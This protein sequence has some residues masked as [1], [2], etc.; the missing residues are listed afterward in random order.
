MRIQRKRIAAVIA[1]AL[2]VSTVFTGLPILKSSAASDGSSLVEIPLVNAGFE[3]PVETDGKI[4]GWNAEYTAASGLSHSVSGDSFKSGSKSLNLFDNI[5]NSDPAVSATAL[6]TSDMYEIAPGTEYTL[7]A[8]INPNIPAGYVNGSVGGSIYIRYYA[9]DGTEIDAAIKKA[10]HNTAQGQFTKVSVTQTAPANAKYVTASAAVTPVWV[11][12]TYFDD[13]SIAYSVPASGTVAMINPGFEDAVGPDNKIPGWNPEYTTVAGSVYHQIGTVARTGSKSLN[14]FDNVN[15]AGVTLLSDRY[16]VIP[17]KSYTLSAW[18]NRNEPVGRVD[19]SVGGTIHLRFYDASG[20]EITASR[21][22][23]NVNNSTQ[24]AF[25]Q[26]ATDPV[27][28]P[29]NAKSAAAAVMITN[30]W[31]GNTY[32]DDFTLTYTTPAEATPTPSIAPSATPSA[33]PAP[34][35]VVVPTP[36]AKPGVIPLLNPEFEYVNADGSIPGWNVGYTATADTYHEVS[37]DRAKTGSKSLKITDLTEKSNVLL[38]SDAYAIEEGVEYTASANIYLENITIDP[39]KTSIAA[40]LLMRFVDA[41]G[42]EITTTDGNGST[43]GMGLWHHRSPLDA[44]TEVSVKA[45]APPGAKF[46][47]VMASVSNYFSAVAYYDDFKITYPVK[48]END[49]AKITVEVPIPNFGF[50]KGLSVDGSIPDWSQWWEPSDKAFYELT[51]ARAKTGSYSLKITDSVED[52]G[53]IL[54][55]DKLPVTAG[56]EYTAKAQMY[57]E[58]GTTAA[59]L[60]LRFYDADDKQIGPEGLFHFR[61]PMN[62]WFEAD[63]KAVAPEGV[64]YARVFASVSNFFKAVAYYD[65]F[66]L[67]YEKDPMMLAIAA[68]AYAAKG[69]TVN[70]G[71]GVN[72]AIDLNKAQLEMGYDPNAIEIVEVTAHPDFANGKAVDLSWSANNGVLTVQAAHKNNNAA[73]GSIGVVNVK[74]KV[75]DV[76]GNTIISLKNT[77]QLISVTNGVTT[78]TSFKSDVKARLTIQQ[79]VHDLNHDDAVDLIDLLTIAKNAGKPIDSSTQHFDLNSDG[80]IDE[81]DVELL[82]QILMVE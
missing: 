47:R 42:N 24:G 22:E 29:A 48:E 16:D 80:R 46:V 11:G 58:D 35:P 34:T 17:G 55:S 3:D 71:L 44:W 64:S 31:T 53:V 26:I 62:Q 70:V 28:A 20:T 38:R 41:N 63:V 32:F 45:T 18:M 37:T 61:S 60:L 81:A 7:S 76:I 49:G 2:L 25:A 43:P 73:S 72:D 40:S 50:E 4:P 52:K 13:F 1:L 19:G 69:Q 51:T 56:I 12:N 75:L 77:S 66:K 33:T 68:P 21:K 74:V 10:H 82:A 27:V 78:T 14:L 6:M 8:W 30:Y 36:E 9:A 79:H 57:L 67:T 65:D 59:S 54:Q 23:K 39:Q 5:S 15:D